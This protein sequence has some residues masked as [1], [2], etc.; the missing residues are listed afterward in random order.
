M[1]FGAIIASGT[2]NTLL[3]QALSE[4]LIEV[5]VEQSLDEPT[6]FGIRVREDISDGEPMAAR[7]AELKK[8]QIISIAVEKDDG[9]LCLVRGPITDSQA[10]FTL[11]GPGS[12]FE[13]HGTDRRGELGRQCIQ[14]AWEGRASDAAR[15]VLGAYGFTP[16]V[17]DTNHVYTAAKET[18][19]QRATDLDFLKTQARENGFF[20][21][22]TFD[23]TLAGT[24]LTVTE[25]AHFRDRGDD[26]RCE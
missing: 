10:E 12:W 1:S 14:T 19:N 17:Q 13:V 20:F 6:R 9:L 18:L 22:L 8:D 25:T 2:S 16:D 4:C 21:W 5:R 11:G 3:S 7:A 26:V 15:T 24:A 23:A